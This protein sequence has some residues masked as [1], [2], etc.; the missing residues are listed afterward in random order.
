MKFIMKMVVKPVNEHR[1]ECFSKG[2]HQHDRKGAFS[3]TGAV[4]RSVIVV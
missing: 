4:V 3:S 2:E 1:Y